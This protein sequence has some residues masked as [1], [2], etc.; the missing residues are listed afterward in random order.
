M[1]GKRDEKR[2]TNEGWS[3]GIFKE[4]IGEVF[5][6][7]GWSCGNDM[8]DAKLAKLADAQKVEGKSG[9]RGPKLR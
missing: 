6:D 5:F 9:E 2:R 7:M 4:G 8:G 1:G 3:E